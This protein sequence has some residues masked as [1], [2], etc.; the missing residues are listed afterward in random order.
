MRAFLARRLPEPV[1]RA[2]RPAY[3]LALRSF[4][5]ARGFARRKRREHRR[6][7]AKLR[8]GIRITM[9]ERK[10]RVRSKRVAKANREMAAPATAGG[11][12]ARRREEAGS[13]RGVARRLDAEQRRLSAEVERLRRRLRVVME[14]SADPHEAWLEQRLAVA[15]SRQHRDLA[16]FPGGAQNPYLRLLYSRCIEAGFD[17]RPLARYE[18]LDRLPNDGVFH[19]HWTRV[20]QAGAES[21]EKAG[22]QSR[23]YLQ[24]IEDFLERGGTLVW[25]VHEAL[26]HDCD[27]PELEIE[28][29]TRL[30]ELATAVHVLHE[31]TRGEVAG[32]YP[33]DPA[34]VL[35]VEH[36]LYSGVYPD[37]VTRS[38]ARRL[39]GV[40][41]DEVLL[42]GFGAIRPYKGF[43]R[44]V[45]LLPRLRE[46]TGLPVR[47]II[48]GPSYKT[49]ENRGLLQLVDQ[50]EGAVV[51]D[52]AV[53]DEYVQVLFRAADVAVLPYR[54]VLNSGVLMLAL[55]FGC[56]AVVSENPVTRDAVGSGLVHVFDRVSDEGLL[57][58][59]VEAIERRSEREIR[60]TYSRRC[61]PA[62]LASQF[63]GE[64]AARV[65]AADAP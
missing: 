24:R 42:L 17:P 33:L 57:A 64:L 19:L 13:R 45:R 46:Q 18:H 31:S 23:A 55:T 53:P 22:G 21:E 36:P 52:R 4:R 40:A 59:V 28:T 54:Q 35:V 30:G 43:D 10:V 20:F 56:P 34:K 14:K 60:E 12:R 37:Y 15:G 48:A 38:A 9:R 7:W 5:R 44:L 49:V 51:M 47:V 1:K 61:D 3:Y 6:A 41:D 50:A 32:L 26:P 65:G 62:V 63:A 25:S 27:Y 8:R 2:L 29:R 58:A 16:Y 11:R 39:L